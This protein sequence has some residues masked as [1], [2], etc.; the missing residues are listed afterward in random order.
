M[1]VEVREIVI[2]ATINQE[3]EES[4]GGATND[5]DKEA[6]ITECVDQILEILKDKA[7]R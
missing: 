7:A 3:S 6:I 1:P 2:K 5:E 4:K